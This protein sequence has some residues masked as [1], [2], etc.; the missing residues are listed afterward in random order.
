M[1]EVLQSQDMVCVVGEGGRVQLQKEKRIVGNTNGEKK[2]K[3]L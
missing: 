1:G 3:T 2:Y